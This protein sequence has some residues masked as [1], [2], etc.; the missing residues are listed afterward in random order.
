MIL[1]AKV[2]ARTVVRHI[3]LIFV[4]NGTVLTTLQHH[5]QQIHEDKDL[6]MSKLVDFCS[7]L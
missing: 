4:V 5:H 6:S 2:V 7:Q 3:Q 1:R